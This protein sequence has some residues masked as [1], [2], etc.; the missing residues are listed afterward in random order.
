[1]IKYLKYALWLFFSIGI[2][3]V[4]YILFTTAPEEFMTI[5]IRQ[6]VIGF[7]IKASL[8]FIGFFGIKAAFLHLITSLRKHRFEFQEELPRSIFYSV[9]FFALAFFLALILI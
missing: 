2:T 6:I 8:A 4:S 9:I 7:L 5:E 3:V 1:M